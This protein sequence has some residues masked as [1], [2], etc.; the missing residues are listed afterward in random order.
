MTTQ[1]GPPLRFKAVNVET[2]EEY[3]PTDPDSIEIFANG[4]WRVFDTNIDSD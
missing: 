2:G 1:H 3:I 4:Y